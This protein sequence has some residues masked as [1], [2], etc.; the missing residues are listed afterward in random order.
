MFEDSHC[1]SDRCQ[2]GELRGWTRELMTPRLTAYRQAGR[3]IL[4]QR[5]RHFP[6]VLI[7]S[8]IVFITQRVFAAD[9]P[10]SAVD[11]DHAAKRAKGLVLF[12][13]Q[14]R[15]LLKEKC[16]QCHGADIT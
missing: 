3:R 12:K 1:S 5:L 13:S 10:P 16:L 14:V 2:Y 6:I 4:P 9:Q 15:S 8:L 11:P 7:V